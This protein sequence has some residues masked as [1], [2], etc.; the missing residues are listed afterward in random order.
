MRYETRE[1][2]T[3]AYQSCSDMQIAHF[4]RCADLLEEVIL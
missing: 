3:L 4:V 1:R 2:L